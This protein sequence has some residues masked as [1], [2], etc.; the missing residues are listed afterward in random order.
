MPFKTI[1]VHLDTEAHAG[2]LSK[3]AIGVAKTFSAHLIGLHVIPDAFISSTVPPE[4]VGELMEAQHL[5]NQAA[6]KRIAETFNQAIAGADVP[7][8]W[9]SVE[10]RLEATSPIVMRHGCAADLVILGQ[11]DKSI[12]LIDGIAATEEVMLGV[13]RPV[14]VVPNAAS[15][16]TIGKR[17]LLGWNGSRESAR[18]AFDALPF[19]EQAD[20][21]RILA[22]GQATDTVLAGRQDNTAPTAGIES[23]LARH[24]VRSTLV[25]ATA[26]STEVAST[27]LAEANSNNCDLIVMGG[28]GHW[29]LREIVFGGATHG[30]LEHTTIPVLMSH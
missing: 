12:N 9:L 1:L 29:R 4:V 14:L 19:L 13:G 23:T 27:L 15:V 17:V 16:S 2:A 30:V 6:G 25:N 26:S 28:Y 18:A 24:G 8:N 5:A 7:F 3:A 21:V 22:A 20:N 11:P 10:A